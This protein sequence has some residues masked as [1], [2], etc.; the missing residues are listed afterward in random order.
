MAS[1]RCRIVSNRLP[2]VRRNFPIAT[3]HRIQRGAEYGKSIAQAKSRVDTG[4]MRAG[5]RVE[6]AGDGFALVNDVAH[7]V[8]NEYGT[9]KMTAQPMAHPAAD[10]VQARWPDLFA[11]FEGDLA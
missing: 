4:Q 10:A 6:A 5:W 9:H 1:V 2:T 7:T 3:A 8:Y 11:G